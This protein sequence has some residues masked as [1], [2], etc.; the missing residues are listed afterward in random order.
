MAIGVIAKLRVQDGKNG[1]FEALF[2]KLEQAV[3]ENEEGCK[4][5]ALHQSRSDSQLYVVIEQY[6]DETALEA[7]RNTDHYKQIGAQL[8]AFAAAA[9]EIELFDSV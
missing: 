7:H 8:G 4:F 3:N 2:A 6:T 5:Y 9:P 1:E